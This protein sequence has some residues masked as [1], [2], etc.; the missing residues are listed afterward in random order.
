MYLN[1]IAKI[2]KLQEKSFPHMLEEDTIWKEHE[3]Q[4]HLKIFPE[5]QFSVEYGDEIIGSSSSLIVELNPEYTN[6]SFREITGRGLFTTHNPNGDTLYG[7]DISVHP[8][9]RRLGIATLLYKTR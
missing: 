2:V 7:A 5:G 9:F 3:L 1:D 6:H 8:D 4:S